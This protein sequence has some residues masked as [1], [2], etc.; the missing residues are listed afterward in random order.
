M[1]A[2]SSEATTALASLSSKSQKIM[3]FYFMP[4]YFFTETN[5]QNNIAEI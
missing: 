2:S 5:I 3:T 1:V 4:E